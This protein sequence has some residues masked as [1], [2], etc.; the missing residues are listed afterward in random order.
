MDTSIFSFIMSMAW[1]SI[2]ILFGTILRRKEGFVLKYGVNFIL[3]IMVVGIIRL[4]LPIEPQFSYVI[5]SKSFMPSCQQFL[6]TEVFQILGFSVNRFD[7]FIAI[8]T[9]GSV[10]YL[11][12]ILIGI[13]KITLRTKKLV[14]VDNSQAQRIM[15]TIV[16]DSKTKQKNRIIVSEN[17]DTPM[18]VGLFT[19]TI[20]LP[21]LSLSDEEMRCVLLHEWNHFLHKHLWV[22][23]FFNVLCALLWWN[24]L[25]YLLKNDLD[26]IQEVSCDRLVVN[27]VG[28]SE[29]V[30][31]V[32]ATMNVMKQLA[33]PKPQLA[34][35]SIGFI[36]T[37]SERIV[38]RC[39]LVLFPPKRFN[40][41]VQIT[42]GTVLL[43]LV[44]LSYVFIVQPFTPPP[45]DDKTSPDGE[46]ISITPENSYLT[47]NGDETYKLFFNGQLFDTIDSSQADSL[48]YSRLPIKSEEE[49]K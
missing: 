4:F 10:V 5:M 48:P 36:A 27:G 49:N 14:S 19:P 11:T 12:G 30:K 41:C 18:L 38:Q 34:L 24:P 8:W 2:F 32:E 40:K 13:M 35:S 15:N 43:V 20:L 33:S 9:I 25:V 23:L 29:R 37:N 1:C 46:Y 28:D 39:E 7:V 42:L 26:Y 17:V 22:K 6:K 31:Y 44:M 21:A 3:L 16:L 45:S 47:K